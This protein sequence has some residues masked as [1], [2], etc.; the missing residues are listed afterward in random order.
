METP[1]TAL[2]P[3]SQY[4]NTRSFG[5]VPGLNQDNHHPI[6]PLLQSSYMSIGAC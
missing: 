2:S 6:A 3:L 4:N 1:N 5:T